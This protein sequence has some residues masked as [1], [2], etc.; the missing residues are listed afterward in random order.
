M[1]MARILFC[2]THIIILKITLPQ[3]L[4][5]V[6]FVEEEH[7]IVSGQSGSRIRLAASSFADLRFNKT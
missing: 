1:H 5:E 6:L 7:I 3:P 2:C 4:V